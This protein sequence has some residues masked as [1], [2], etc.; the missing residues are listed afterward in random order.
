MS[1]AA[2][3]WFSAAELAAMNLPGMPATKPGVLKRVRL[4]GWMGA[5]DPSV[6]KLA[7]KRKGRGGGFEFH[8][9][10]LPE[11]ARVRLASQGAAKPERLDRESAWLRWEKLPNGLKS[12]A[13]AR[14]DVI[15][16][17]EA[18]QQAGLNKSRAIEQVV[19]LAAAEAQAKG[20]AP[21][22]TVS[23]LY[24]WFGRIDGVAREDRVVFLAPDYAGRAISADTCAPDAWEFF[25]G[26]Y[27][28]QSKPPAAGSYRRLQRV[29]QE[30]G[31]A[32]PS[33]KTLQR[34]LDA[35]VPPPVQTYY[36]NGPEALLH[37]FP[38]RDR[39]RSG[40]RPMQILNLD[41]H[42]WDVMVE[43]PNGTKSRPHALV[44]QDIASGKILA[45]RHD[46]TLNHHLVRLALG[47]T[48]REH[49]LCEVI[50]MDNGRENAAQA[51]SGGQRRLRWGKTPEE[52]PAG[53]LKTLGIQAVA[54]TPY[55]GKAKPIERSFRDFAHD[56]A[57]SPEFDG[58][59]TGHNTVSKPEN[60]GSRAI[61]FAEFEAIVRREIAFYNAQ[62]GRRGQGMNGR[63]FDE[64]FTAGLAGV[65]RPVVSEQQLRLCLLASK[66]VS[67]EPKTGAVTVEGHRYWSPE[68][69]DVK[70][71]PVTVRFDPERLDLPA[72]V[73]SRDNRLL[74]KA[75]RVLA[76]SFDSV[77][78]A[79]EQRRALRDYARA[80]KAEADAI[81][82]LSPQDVAARLHGPA[83]PSPIA[84]TENVVAPNFKVP[85][86]ADQL[87]R[88]A[89]GGGG[90]DPTDFDAK[91]QAGIAGL[92]AGG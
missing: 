48:F 86:T 79:R 18:L 22:V 60:Y 33:L 64:L 3:E 61:P 14:L 74:A 19:R 87:G 62:P 43:W 30:N 92:A 49:G 45:I 40:I 4:E 73:Y 70:R 81:R 80:K 13:Q 20:E 56:L 78:D 54:V 6:G 69:G 82:R 2:Q 17:V 90:P 51:I 35:E 23:T 89:K 57:K 16:Q 59:Y 39:D 46:L 50:L 7:R 72:Y 36:R 67:M 63:S 83:M 52:E 28:R 31:W 29:A 1:R 91:W 84:A 65:V 5:A 34:R 15:A 47:D 75:D 21:P 8:V 76:G 44:V 12:E 32:V 66:L 37:T 11:A 55:W 88:F 10:L 9:S 27:L 68:L 41:G 26:D 77:T 53:L 42:T 38:H 25:K 58:A 24:A 71:Q 85:R